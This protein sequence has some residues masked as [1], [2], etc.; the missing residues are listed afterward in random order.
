MWRE[1]K[2]ILLLQKQFFTFPL[3][4]LKLFHIKKRARWILINVSALCNCV[5][6]QTKTVR[7]KR[8]AGTEL[9]Q[10][11]KGAQEE[12]NDASL[13]VQEQKETA[14][15]FK[16]KYFAAIEKVHKV[17]AQLEHLQEELRYSEQQVRS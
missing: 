1:S 10:L 14:M 9:H 7:E 5:C 12:L 13:Q 6:F 3:F 8:D 4:D 11:F 15:I 16:Q 17:Q 2:S